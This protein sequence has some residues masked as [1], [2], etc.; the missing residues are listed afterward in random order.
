MTVGAE[1]NQVMHHIAAELAPRL[2][3]MNLSLQ[4]P[5]PDDCILFRIQFEPRSLLVERRRVR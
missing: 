1:G 2:H 4:H 3:V 5:F